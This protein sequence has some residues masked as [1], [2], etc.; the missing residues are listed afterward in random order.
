VTRAGAEAAA[1]EAEAE[2]RDRA[3]QAQIAK[4]A[5]AYQDLKRERDKALD[6]VAALNATVRE[7]T[8]AGTDAKAKQAEVQQASK[9]ELDKALDEVAALKAA[10]GELTQG[11]EHAEVRAV[12]LSQRLRKARQSK[13]QEIARSIGAA[14]S[15]L[16]IAAAVATLGFWTYQLIW[17]SPQKPP[18]VTSD[19]EQQRLAAV[20]ADFEE[21]LNAAG[22][23]QQR[24]KDEVQGLTKAA[25]NAETKLSAAEAEQARQ[26][27]AATDADTKRKAA[28][29][30]QLRLKEEVQRQT[31]ALADAEAKRKA[32]EAQQ[33][34]LQEEVQ[35]QAKLATDAET[36]RKA[37]EGEQQ[38]L[39]EEVQRQA[40]AT[41]KGPFTIKANTEAVNPAPSIYYTYYIGNS[42]AACEEICTRDISCKI[43]S[44][45]KKNGM[46]YRY[47][48]ADFK[49]NEQFDTGIRFEQTNP[50]ADIKVAPPTSPAATQV[51]SAG[52]LSLTPEARAQMLGKVVG[53]GCVG[54]E[55]FYMGTGTSGLTK[56]KDFWSVRCRDGR[57][58]QVQANSDGTSSVLECSVYK[59]IHA[60]ECFK[61][62]AP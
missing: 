35:R 6:K 20:R 41:A 11:R 21:K 22:A 55:T 26:A 40:N 59:V 61:P 37:A 50:S 31:R 46:C 27:K 30:E 51:S 8:Q 36:K 57:S 47:N 19:S 62:L 52:L 45:D 9:R 60:G 10:V 15:P 38:R 14:F 4:S 48:Q 42:R 34:R 58:Y 39:K 49:S 2:R 44:F 53:E 33:Q 17:S 32:A 5:G 24:L 25:A 16:V 56:D 28:E 7:L 54:K 13:A 43:F 12:E 29:A 1:R 18:A 3:L 23:E